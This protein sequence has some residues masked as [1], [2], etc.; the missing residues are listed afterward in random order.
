MPV[1]MILGSGLRADLIVEVTA[2]RNG[3]T[4]KGIASNDG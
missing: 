4:A 3:K 2:S 1:K